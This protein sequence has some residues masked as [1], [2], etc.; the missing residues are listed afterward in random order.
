MLQ[1][2]PGELLK[3]QQ[4]H[5]K[6]NKRQWRQITFLGSLELDESVSGNPIC[7]ARRIAH[8]VTLTFCDILTAERCGV[9]DTRTAELLLLCHHNSKNVPMIITTWCSD[10]REFSDFAG[11]SGHLL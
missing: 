8:A 4:Q 10:Y 2:L 11:C 6:V 7:L 9:H 5:Q 1:A 3:L